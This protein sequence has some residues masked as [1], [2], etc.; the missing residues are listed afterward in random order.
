MK[1]IFDNAE[2]EMIS[3]EMVDI[4]TT[5]GDNKPFPGEDDEI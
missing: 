2:I 1:K 5:S 4:I 3:F